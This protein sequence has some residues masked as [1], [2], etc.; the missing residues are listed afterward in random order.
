MSS[1]NVVIA[2]CRS[3]DTAKNLHA[4]KNDAKGTL[5]ILSLDTGSFESIEAVKRPVEEIVGDHGL[6]Y[7]LNNAGMVHSSAL[8]CAY[9]G[10]YR[11]LQ[12]VGNDAAFDFKPEDLATTFQINVV[13]PAHLTW[14][15]LP[16]LERGKRK[17]IMNMSSSLGSIALDSGPVFATYSVSKA[18]V[19][20][21]VSVFLF[22]N[23]PSYSHA[24]NPT[25]RHT[26][27]RN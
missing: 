4:L 22:C 16:L 7:L 13:G 2:T 20:M 25:L 24:G 5:H 6:D 3:P 14:T 10:S 19:N 26:S 12:N 21:L 15:L 9:T 11:T 18:A 23:E 1:S 8:L 27:S 17:V